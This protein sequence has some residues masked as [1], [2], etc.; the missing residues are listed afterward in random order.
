MIKH[1]KNSE[2]DPVLWDACVRKSVISLPYALFDYLNV[3]SPNW[4]G[5]VFERN[6]QYEWVF[7]LPVKRK[8]GLKYLS[9][10]LF[11]QQLGFYY[12]RIPLGS[13]KT[14]VIKLLQQKFWL[15]DIADNIECETGESLGLN[16]SDR[17]T[18]ILDLSQSFEKIKSNYNSNRKRV[19]NKLSSD[20]VIEKSDSALKLL[21]MF[22][23]DK[24]SEVQGFDERAKEILLELTTNEKLQNMFSIYYVTEK[25]KEIAGGLFIEFNHK[26]IFLFGATSQPGKKLNA[27]TYLFNIS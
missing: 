10:P 21:K 23:L 16:E 5:I 11:T 22:E 13:E 2:I 1:L 8:M 4:E 25:G 9:Q 3:V 26:I 17:L 6:N 19:L 15:F 24:G 14:E 12:T 7:A 27:I 18:H 20:L